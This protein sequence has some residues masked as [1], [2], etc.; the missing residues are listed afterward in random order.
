V[1][2]RISRRGFL[3][4]GATVA[5]AGYFHTA[6]ARSADRVAAGPNG[7]VQFAGIGVGGKGS[8]DI[9]Q[10]AKLG[11]VVAICDIDENHLNAKANEKARDTGEQHF[12]SAKRYFDYRKL[13]DEMHRDIDAVLV[14]T[15][16]HTHAPAAIMAM[17]LKKHAY[18]QKPLCHT[19]FEARRMR[20]VAREYGVQTQM[21]NQG[22]AANG[23]RRAV[24]L[25]QAGVLGQVT[26][27][28]VWTNRPA[29]YWKQA[30]DIT[31]R[32]PEKPVPANVHWDEFLGSAPVRPYGEFE[33]PGQGSRRGSSPYHPS[34]WRGWWDFGTGAMGDMACHTANMPFRALKLGVPTSIVADA[35]DLNQETYP[36]SA[37]VTYQFPARG[38]MG[39]VKY[40]WY[41]GKR[42]GKKLAP[43]DDL[44]VKALGGDAKERRGGKLVDSGSILVGTKG[45]LYAPGDDGAQA[46]FSPAESFASLQKREP[47]NMPKNGKGDDGM[48]IE[49]V[50]AIKGGA[51]PY[52]NFDFAGVMV[53]AILLGNVAIRMS[54]TKLDW[55]GPNLKFTNSLEATTYVTKEYR[56]GFSI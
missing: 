41:E 56:K 22:S 13:L 31:S 45:I 42:D 30:P 24:E 4:T 17:K 10:A 5:C 12:L 7:R 28:H 39:P 27:A 55:D 35:T 20:E 32:P 21:G 54:G 53:E 44:V 3:K 50:E 29:Q 2:T 43:P 18:V 11:P 47:K 33:R 38:E 52:S 37:R 36:S 48:K 46:Y 19:V 51:A 40:V 23:L 6:T 34:A 26:E 49:W 9:S 16:D 8:G 15:P 25:V 1:S 14:G